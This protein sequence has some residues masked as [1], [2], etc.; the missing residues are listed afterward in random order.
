MRVICTSRGV[1]KML[2]C[3]LSIKKY[4]TFNRSRLLPLWH[5]T[6]RNSDQM[7]SSGTLFQIFNYK[8]RNFTNI[9]VLRHWFIKVFNWFV[10]CSWI[11]I[12]FC[13]FY[14]VPLTGTSTSN[15]C[16]SS[17]SLRTLV[18]CALIRGRLCDCCL[19]AT[20]AFAP[21]AWCNW[22]SARCVEQLSRNSPQITRDT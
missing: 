3:A 7:V 14:S 4:G 20:K 1:M 17:V 19:V 16:G 5:L 9:H 6:T 21:P 12:S 10:N 8:E 13:H 15:S 2:G 18:P 11:R 22:Q